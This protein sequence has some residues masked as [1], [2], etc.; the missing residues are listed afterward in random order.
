MLIDTHCHLD[1][2]QFKKDFEA[3]LARAEEA[4]VGKMINPGVG[5]KES[6]QALEL[7]KN[8]ENIFAAVGI[9][10]HEVN[11]LNE[12]VLVELEELAGDPKVVAIG[13]IGLDYFRM[14]NEK[15]VQQEAFRKQLE[16]AQKLKKPVIIHSREAD[17]DIFKILDNFEVRGVFHCFGGNWAFAQQVLERGFLIGLTGVVTFPKAVATHE[18]AKNIPLEKLLV[19]T[20]APFLAAQKF[21]G[22][23]CEPAFVREVAEAIAEI[24]KTPIEEVAEKTTENT[25]NLFGLS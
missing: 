14:R 9:H 1:F 23:R 3:V 21:R 2:P 11:S 17:E 20:D 19:E 16:L 15:T 5:I 12:G 7:A 24:K 6:R 10:P 18:V 25:L 4:G 22:Q 13:E 8:H